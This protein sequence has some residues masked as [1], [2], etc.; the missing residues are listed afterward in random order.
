MKEKLA[1]VFESYNVD[2]DRKGD[3]D[4]RNFVTNQ[5]FPDNTKRDIVR[6]EKIGED[7]YKLTVDDRLSQANADEN[8][9]QKK[10]P[11]GTNKTIDT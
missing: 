5:I 8:N 3:Q 7:A 2:F 10:K 6:M 9:V 11:F 1:T 4:L